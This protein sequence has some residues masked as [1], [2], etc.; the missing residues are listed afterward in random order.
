[1]ESPLNAIAEVPS[2][3][4]RAVDSLKSL[5]LSIREPDSAPIAALIR[6][7]A[8]VDEARAIVIARTIAQQEVFDT[9]VA[10]QVSGMNVGQRFELITKGF[11][12]IRDD[13]KRMVD[14][15][16]D[17]KISIG[18]RVGNVIM[19]VT[20]GDIADRFETIRKTYV[21]VV[22]D[23]QKQIEKEAAILSAYAEFRG[24][25]KE[26]EVIAYE[27]LET[28]EKRLT[29]S[30]E[31]VDAAAKAIETA[32]EISQ[33]DRARLELTRDEKVRAFQVED[34]RYQV[35]KD[36][37]ENLRISYNATEVTMARL[38]QSHTAKERIWKQAVTFFSTNTTVLSAL[39][40]S[41]TGLAGLHE[42]T[43]TVDAMKDGVSKSLETLAEIGGQVQEAAIR[44]GYG[45]TIR[46][47]SVQKLVDSVVG[48]QERSQEIIAEMRVLS[49]KN[50]DEIRQSVETGKK[51]MA[52]LAARG[53]GLN[54]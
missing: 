36:L 6:R 5:G 20:R 9:V 52:A 28:A 24:A 13:A 12:S 4:V 11:D 54:V 51:K 46:S 34:D 44:S 50:A 35:A 39:K 19:K 43:K 15:L 3:L 2:Y 31:Q 22:G 27:I 49:T 45:P 1:M 16:A 37:A 41:F 23:V 40:A 21:E 17:G 7:I 18:E 30:R 29:A 48:F 14:Q 32:T 33:A 10:D 38:A 47:E 26:A 8:E 25:L 42:A 53:N